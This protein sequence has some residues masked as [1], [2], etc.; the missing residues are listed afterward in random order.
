[1]HTASSALGPY[2]AG[3]D[4]QR[5]AA[6]PKPPTSTREGPL[7]SPF[8]GG[9]G[10]KEPAE[11]ESAND[12]LE[13]Q[14]EAADA[15]IENVSFASYGTAGCE[16]DPSVPKSLRV[17][18]SELRP[19]RGNCR[20]SNTLLTAGCGSQVAAN[21][22]C[23]A[24]NSL[25]STSKLCVG[26]R[27]CLVANGAPTFSSDPCYGIFKSLYVVARCSKGMGRVSVHSK[28]GGGPAPGVTIPSQQS[29]IVRLPDGPGKQEQWLW[30]GDRWQSGN[31]VDG[32][33]SHDSM[34]WVPMEFTPDGN[35]IKPL[36]YNKTWAVQLHVPATPA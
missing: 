2:T 28:G 17:E 1:M 10:G 36:A 33:K 3:T 13:L 31:E 19:E 26:K 22:S 20:Y 15:V 32:F 16:W 9:V 18:T 8:C 29:F 4:I 21:S 25:A 30:G 23:N 34:V 5:A 7:G 6:P 35:D 24:P 11:P 27:S 12:V 14:C